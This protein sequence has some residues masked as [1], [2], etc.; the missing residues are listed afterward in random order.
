MEALVEL[1]RLRELKRDPDAP[2]PGSPREAVA[3]YF[4]LPPL[5][6]IPKSAEKADGKPVR[7]HALELSRLLLLKLEFDKKS[8]D[9]ADFIRDCTFRD[10]VNAMQPG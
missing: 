2:V 8:R 4:G 6:Q 3:R 1:E 9:F 7:T 10:D 5:D